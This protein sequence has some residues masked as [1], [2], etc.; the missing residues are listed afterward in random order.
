MTTA[1][2]HIIE[3]LNDA[4]SGFTSSTADGVLNKDNVDKVLGEIIG[5]AVGTAAGYVLGG[6]P[7]GG[8]IGAA[9]GTFL[10][11]WG[12]EA[13][14]GDV[15]FRGLL[16]DAL[17]GLVAGTVGGAVGQA[18]LGPL[19][20]P[21]LP[22]VLTQLSE[23]AASVIGGGIGSAIAA[24]LAGLN[25]IQNPI[26]EDISSGLQPYVQP[27]QDIWYAATAFASQEATSAFQSIENLFQTAANGVL[28][29]T[30]LT[31]LFADADTLNQMTSNGDF[32]GA[33]APIPQGTDPT[34]TL[35]SPID[36]LFEIAAQFSADQ[37]ASQNT[38][39]DPSLGALELDGS[40]LQVDLDPA[41]W[42]TTYGS[43]RKTIQGVS[44]L[45][46]GVLYNV[47]SIGPT[48]TVGG[49]NPANAI[50]NFIAQ[51]YPSEIDI[52][53]SSGATLDS[54]G[55]AQSY[56]SSTANTILIGQSD[57][58]TIQA[59]DGDNLIFGGNTVT[60]GNGANIIVGEA[61]G[62]TITVG[63]GDNVVIGAGSGDTINI[64]GLAPNTDPSADG[65]PG[66]NYVY[67]GPGGGTIN[68]DDSAGGQ[69][70]FIILPVANFSVDGLL[71]LDQNALTAA[72][73]GELAFWQS[74]Y[75]WFEPT[76]T[77]GMKDVN[78]TVILAP[79]GSAADTIDINGAPAE[80]SGGTVWD[81]WPGPVQQSSDKG[82]VWEIDQGL[83]VLRDE[84]SP[85]TV[86][87]LS[88]TQYLVQSGS[89]GGRSG[90]GDGGG[91]DDGS[92][93]GNP[94][95]V[96]VADFDANQS[97]FD[98]TNG[99]FS[100][101]DTAV[102][103]SDAI[104]ALNEDANI[105]GI[106]LTDGGTPTLS[107]S[108][109]Q[110]VED[111]VA[112]TKI[113]N[114]SYA[115][116]ISDLA[117]NVSANIDALNAD[118]AVA[119]ITLTDT[120]TPTLTL[121]VAQA[122]GDTT[123]LGKI[124]NADYAISLSDT[125]AN[126]SLSID[127]INGDAHI[128]S[129]TLT[130]SGTP[131]LDLTIAQAFGDTTALGEITNA[132]FAIAIYDTAANILANETALGADSRIASVTAV[133][134]ASN[135]LTDASALAADTEVTSN[136][137]M[138]TAANAL[139]NATA[140]DADAQIASITVVD[141]AANIAADA[142]DLAAVPK[143]AGEIVSDTAANVSANFDALNA[144][145]SIRAIDL[146]DS[147]VPTLTLTVAQTL[148]DVQA[149]DAIAN[150]GYAIDV[151]DTAANV[152]ANLDALSTNV[153]VTA[154]T[155]TGD[156]TPT[157]IL[158]S[159]QAASDDLTLGEITNA[160]YAIT[161]SDTAAN[162][163]ANLDA[164]NA[165]S[166]LTSIALTDSG[167]PILNLTA[168]QAADDTT[169]LSKIV[170][171][172][173]QITISD[174]A[175]NVAAV[176]D[177][178][179]SESQIFSITLTDVE[180]PILSLTASQ[181][182]DDTGTLGKITNSDYAIAVTDTV[183]NVLA[184]ATAL[185]ADPRITSISISDTAANILTDASTLSTDTW[186]SSVNVVDSAED[187]SADL[188]SL[189]GESNLSIALTDTGTP[190]LTLT[191]DQADSKALL[192]V[193]NYNY[194]IAIS[195]TAANVSAAFDALNGNSHV[196]SITLTDSGTPMLTLTA[197]QA[198]E[199]TSALSEITNTSYTIAISDTAANVSQYFSALND[200]A[201]LSSI[202]LTGS[203]TP[204]LTL[205]AAEAIGDTVALGKI[206]NASY[207]IAIVDTAA[208]VLTDGSTLAGM[209]DISSVM[210]KDTAADIL[211]NLSELESDT[212]ISSIVVEDTAADVL[213]N[214]TALQDAGSSISQIDVV[215]T[216][217]D[218]AS[219]LN[220]L[221]GASGVHSITLTDAGSPITLTLTADE[222]LNDG[223]ALSKIVSDYQI[224]VVDTASNIAANSSALEDDFSIS[225]IS[226]SDTVANV[227]AVSGTLNYAANVIDT[228]ANVVANLNALN[229]DSD[230]SSI[231]LTDSGTITLTLTVAQALDD[232]GALD[233]ITNS[234][235]QIA[236]AD[237]AANVES[238]ID[239]LE[240]FRA[241]ANV[242]SITLTDT[243]TPTLSLTAEQ[244]VSDALA[245]GAIDNTNYTVAVRSVGS[246]AGSSVDIAG[247][248]DLVSL[249][250]DSLNFL[251]NTIAT[252]SGDGDSIS[253]NASD[254]ITVTGTD[255]SVTILGSGDS[256]FSDSG[257]TTLYSETSA[258]VDGGDNTIVLDGN[259]TLVVTGSGDNVTI[260]G[261]RDNVTISSGIVTMLN[262]TSA[263]VNG[264]DNAVVLYTGDTL[265]DTASDDGVTI[266]GTGDSVT[267]SSGTMT[268]ANDSSATISGTG[269]AIL[270][271]TDDTLTVA[272]SS[273][274]V[275]IEGTGDSVTV[276][277]GNVTMAND[278]NATLSG[279]GNAILLYTDDTL[280]DTGSS[281]NVTIEG[282]DDSVS[283]TSA[284]LTTANDSS[285]TVSGAGN[286]I[287][288]YTDDA[289]TITGSSDNVTVEG[290]GD[291]AAMSS[292]NVTMLNDAN[293][294]VSGAGNAIL[295]YTGDTLTVTGSSD[296][297]TV[298]GTGD[299][300]AIGS[301]NVT[302]S[303]DSSATVSG[304]GNAI[305]LYTDDTLAVT[306]SGNS[307]SIY[308]TT[309]SG[310]I[311]SGTVT[312]SNSS[313]A[314]VSGSD[315]AIVLYADDT[316][317]V[318]GS[319]NSVSL[320]GTNDTA[321]SAGTGETYNFGAVNGQD[322]I[323]A[324]SGTNTGSVALAS[325]LTD[326]NLWFQQ[327]G[328]NLVVDTVGTSSSLT[329][330]DWFGGTNAA[331][332]QSFTAGGLTL[333]TQVAQLVSAMATYSANNS[334]FN[335]ATAT[336]MPT[337]STLQ[338]AIAAAWHS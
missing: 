161:V 228:A 25:Q 154:I 113:T 252:V 80:I 322:V 210:V 207:S 168:A 42:T 200:D 253:L 270:L 77:D 120:G 306:G 123:A 227:L 71:D 335:P 131:T 58:G 330:D 59:G 44:D 273:D 294:T 41:E 202:T 139:A 169:A 17:G 52:A 97:S 51:Q 268:M 269:N 193:A 57:N 47:L 28:T 259:D 184:N 328:D 233:K 133:D 255:D 325:S 191:V 102:N 267:I 144:D 132:T 213:A 236:I 126:V 26:V 320:E 75:Q 208:N 10:G 53:V 158:T 39:A 234:G 280:T 305:V 114:T 209:S 201:Y 124:S 148:N 106:I 266:E 248:H 153:K 297:V 229:N 4:L 172:S 69:E 220:A 46:A 142:S 146:T 239:A 86:N 182:L 287:L 3:L 198:I 115:I 141:T 254:A 290:T 203:G 151:V 87:A 336:Q 104:D 214:V 332:V 128:T 22:Q 159:D 164:L 246:E 279:A 173:Y 251:N 48:T 311:G 135:L 288:L 256:V 176:L 260:E 333:N 60:V 63:G 265:A 232:S 24:T 118:A 240:A 312:L 181:A 289:L 276:S 100:I 91:S 82:L 223:T 108:A 92:G 166:T 11:G 19:L 286:A 5:A 149:L 263:S 6:G 134:T 1:N 101:I 177:A 35:I 298:E 323:G 14:D 96:T 89:G 95:T 67:A 76:Y 50:N 334:G 163:G 231:T 171:T 235:Y 93:G 299:S 34:S 247:T 338:S 167:T 145:S 310:S 103:V 45:V 61:G 99:G 30:G 319:G 9:I 204:T 313:S 155:L 116:A 329:I 129:I 160:T 241:D 170:N 112:L 262:D 162:V 109:T 302:M 138:D 16:A 105:D 117:A 216:A 157:L 282:T 68:F 143:V 243:G 300:V 79:L 20:G 185:Q 84:E 78:W 88:L 36:A 33:L 296:N 178:L 250:S 225:S 136:E 258:T 55:A 7:I 196:T 264:S 130:D 212:H 194:V 32:A 218:I 284:S 81:A 31:P 261:T 292:G 62:E 318:T 111:T 137:V 295:L 309:D 199:D 38:D 211:A 18:L 186:I 226:I 72:V 275:T 110:A 188:G 303:N 74:Y 215:D 147:G 242:V 43:G 98:G 49:V 65:Q 187:V 40:T 179:N 316:L 119:S 125:A 180:T 190:T 8:G 285:V 15:D 94:P 337:N 317:S 224:A 278:S 107:L 13:A 221:E 197:T 85:V 245:L 73:N 150:A 195:D 274:D 54:I 83:L 327:S 2:T 175:A 249:G 90:G 127:Q 326:E 156:G 66:I 331:A 152:D 291:S 222:A 277:S 314:T 27:A 21:I 237:T 174:R 321:T 301:G 315:N 23:E 272:G 12:A 37:V 217:A 29:N 56:N 70:Q 122:L 257:S 121:S 206:E 192:D 205:T 244:T 189:A 238:N 293:A 283:I 230:I 140:L 64:E 183:A 307:V 281:E 304:A 324:A 271:Y 308:G 165:N 219:N